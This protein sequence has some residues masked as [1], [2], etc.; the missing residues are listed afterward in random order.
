MV[1][2]G[3]SLTA[4]G[5][6][7]KLLSSKRARQVRK[8]KPSLRNT[9]VFKKAQRMLQTYSK[10]GKFSP[11]LRQS[12]S[13]APAKRTPAKQTS[14]SKRTSSKSPMQCIAARSVSPLSSKKACL[15][16]D[17]SRMSTNDSE[18]RIETERVKRMS[19][20]CLHLERKALWLEAKTERE[21]LARQC[22]QEEALTVREQQKHAGDFLQLIKE[23]LERSKAA[24]RQY[25]DLEWATRKETHVQQKVLTTQREKDDLRRSSE[26]LSLS[27]YSKA[28][29]AETKRRDREARS[30]DRREFVQALKAA[31]Q[32]DKSQYA[33]QVTSDLKF[34][35]K[36]ALSK[37]RKSACK[38][39]EI[40]RR[41]LDAGFVAN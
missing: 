10:S 4:L 9:L 30:Q 38:N 41:I 6:A 27:A 34:H 12:R 11:L 17:L 1:P 14:A 31:Q 18:L 32:R 2:L 24:E 22:V 16:L 35:L 5:L 33:S 8:A 36:Q 26:Q 29:A 13:R 39:Q 19:N 25:R 28:C 20:Y 15:S 21:V 3:Q 23:E 7:A 40:V 37:D